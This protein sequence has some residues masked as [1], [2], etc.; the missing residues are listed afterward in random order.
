MPDSA[1]IGFTFMSMCNM[2]YSLLVL[3]RFSTIKDPAWDR[4]TVRGLVDILS[5][6][7]KLAENYATVSQDRAPPNGGPEKSDYFSDAESIFRI[8]RSIW[9]QQ[10]TTAN[11]I[12][13]NY[14]EQ[15]QQ[16]LDELL[17][18]ELAADW[19]N[20]PFLMDVLWQ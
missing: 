7:D 12:P 18:P 13:D 1:Y 17:R 11:L 3:V 10:L 4:G 9:E 14:E 16:L 5:V 20:P 19:A 8:M 2:A 15:T 6:C